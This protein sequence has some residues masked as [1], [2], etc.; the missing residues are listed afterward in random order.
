VSRQ[1]AEPF[2]P[3]LIA[4][5]DRH[6]AAAWPSLIQETS[7]GWTL[8]AF[9]GAGGRRLNTSLTPCRELDAEEIETALERSAAFAH[10][11]RIPQRIQISPLHLHGAL[12]SALVEQAW[13]FGPEI[14][15]MSASVAEIRATGPVAPADDFV[16]TR[17]ADDAWLASR[18]RCNPGS[19][20][21][22]LRR[23]V[24]PLLTGRAHFCRIGERAVGI[25][26]ASDGLVA[27]FA[28][29]VAP[30]SRRQGLG[31]LLVRS[32]LA[33]VEA[34]TAYLQVEIEN[35]AAIALY[36]SLGFLEAFHY[37]HAIAPASAAGE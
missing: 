12:V 24:L 29:A 28:L 7:D 27:L 4:R 33:G 16:I 23:T 6:A 5:I 13:D 30:D 26:V 10:A 36:T 8:R 14:L 18:A 37:L 1:V 22:P 11:Q 15:V 19:D 3:E 21:D 34:E 9:G 20:I 17:E 32:M 25:A 2:P 31:K 35:A